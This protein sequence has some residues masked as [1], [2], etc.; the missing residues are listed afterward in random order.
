MNARPRRFISS[1]A[2]VLLAV[3]V[4]AGPAGAVLAGTN[5]RILFTSGRDSAN[6]DDNEAKLFLRTIIGSSGL[7]LA[8]PT[9]TPSGGQHKHATWSP[10]RTKIVYARGTPGSPL[11]ENFD[12]YVHDLT[13]GAVT[14]ITNTAD[15]L[16]S[17]RP[18]W[19]PDG[20]RIAYEQQPVDNSA[21]RDLKVYTVATGALLDLTTGAPIETRSAWSP[22]SQTIYYAAGDPNVNANIM[23]KPAGGGTATLAV[24]DSGISEFQPSISPDG[25]KICFTLGTGFNGTTEVFTAPLASPATQTNLSNNPGT[26]PIHGDFDCV[27]SPDGTKIAYVTGTFSAGSLVMESSDDTSLSPI[28]IEDDPLNFDGNPDWAPDGR[29]TCQSATVTATLNAPLTIPLTCI[30]NG[31][32]YE[33]TAVTPDIPFDGRPA[34]GSVGAVMQDGG[35]HVVYTPN[36]NFIGT[37]SFQVRVRDEIAFGTVRATVTVR[38]VTP[39]S[40][41]VGSPGAG[42]GGAGGGTTGT[43]GG[44][45][46]DTIAPMIT[47]VSVSPRSWRRGATLPR[48]AKAAVGTKIGWRLSEDAGVTLTFESV[49]SG[50]RVGRR[51]LSSTPTR[52][53]LPR[54]V[55]LRA[56]GTLVRNSAKG[57]QNN[58][59]FSGSLTRSRRLG[60]GRYRVRL[61][62]QDSAGNRSTIRTS[63]TF[64]IVTG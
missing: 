27:W 55:R 34:N 33:L 18:A 22:D 40:G 53:S 64:R 26:L 37:D 25:T 19:S 43:G 60:P 2:A 14:P 8:S 4:V 9:L 56:A 28:L 30:D 13:T 11:T 51:C 61:Q 59:R 52:S 29:P 44:T 50:R 31:P 23:R 45:A 10:D 41:G 54:C 3:L 57:G 7:G 12:I 6:G 24:P 1:L 15:S 39:I 20:T 5:G 32:A 38:V 62:A 17:G 47:Q 16:S 42:G 63:P 36:P 21:E 35:A 46:A 58:L 49:G 48:F